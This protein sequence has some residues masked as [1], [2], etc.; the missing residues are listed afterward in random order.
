MKLG[1]L[2]LYLERRLPG[3]REGTLNPED[4]GF[5]VIRST[6]EEIAE[7]E[8]PHFIR[9][10]RM[11]TGI[12]HP[13]WERYLN[14][15]SYDPEPAQQL[16]TK[17][18]ELEYPYECTFGDAELTITDGVFVPTLTKVSPFL[19]GNVYGQFQPDQRVLDPFTGSSAFG[20]NAAL[21]GSRI[22]S[23]DTSAEAVNCARAN[24]DRNGVAD[25]VKVRHGSW[26]TVQ[27]EETFDLVVANPPLI[28]V[29]PNRPIESALFDEGLSATRGL[30]AALPSVLTK[31]GKCFLVTSDVI[32]RDDYKV[33]ISQLCRDNSLV[34]EIVDQQ[35]WP[36][37]SYRLHQVQRRTSVSWV[38][39]LLKRAVEH[40]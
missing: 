10:V 13:G 28:P 17:L 8:V 33:D 40:L 16:V 26:E 15:Q 27:P 3:E 12:D 19:L 39:P 35:H 32:D 25:T 7:A 14:S 31:R 38:R 37:E 23:F 20:I 29:K 34:T 24:A 9:R 1:P 4:Y 30:I 6:P 18:E 11:R 22:V 21:R 5:Q 36:Y 2:P